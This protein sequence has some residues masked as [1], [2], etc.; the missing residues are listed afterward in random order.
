MHTE[1][2]LATQRS[3]VLSSSRRFLRLGGCGAGV[4]LTCFLGAVFRVFVVVDC[5]LGALVT[6]GATGAGLATTFGLL[7]LR[8]SLQQN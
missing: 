1:S 3:S 6:A 4:A 7:T 8:A 2:G 5:F